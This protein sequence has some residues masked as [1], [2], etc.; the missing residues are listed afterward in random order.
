M[1]A[2]KWT[3]AL[4]RRLA[5]PARAED[6]VGDLEEA[7]ARRAARHARLVADALTSLEALD[8]ALALLRGRARKGRA[9]PDPTVSTPP[10]DGPDGPGSPG[11]IRFPGFSWLELKLGLRMLRKYPGLTLVG[12]LGMAV[13]IAI[14]A[15]FF[16]FFSA[17]IYPT[18]PLEGGDR[19]VGV[20]NWDV[21]RNNEDRRSLHDFVNWR[22]ELTTVEDLTAFRTVSR[23]L[24][25]LD[26]TAELITVAEMTPSGFRLARVRPLLGRYLLAPDTVQGAEPVIVI[27]YDVWQARFGGDPEIIGRTLRLGATPYTVVGV[28]PEGFAFPMEHSF[29]VPLRVNASD[30]PRGFGPSIFISGRLAPGRTMEE[31]QA[32][33]V[34]IGRRATAAF[35]DTHA[36]LRPHVLPYTYPLIDI[37]DPGGGITWYFAVMQMIL[38][39]ILVVVCVN[40]AI[41]VYAR[42]AARQGEIAVRC[43]LGASRRQVVVQLFMEALV[44]SSAAAL[45]GLGI[46]QIGLRIGHR[47]MELEGGTPFWMNYGLTPAT[48]LYVVGLTLLS[49]LITGVLPALQATGRRMQASLR[50]LGGHT[51]LRLGR[52]WTALVVIQVA[53]AV[54]ALPAALAM[55]WQEV[56]SATTRPTYPI[57]EYVLAQVAPDPEPPPGLDQETY[58]E[59]LAVRQEELGPELVRQ[60]RELPGVSGVALSL[61]LPGR[62]SSAAVEVEGGLTGQP[63]AGGPRVEVSLVG[64][65]FFRVFE[66]PLLAGRE[67]GGTDAD[68]ASAAVV[69]NRT[70]AQQLFVGG[71]AVGRRIRL[72]PPESGPNPIPTAD[73][74]WLEIVGVVGDLEVNDFDPSLVSAVVYQPM[75]PRGLQLLNLTVRV[76]EA[77]SV[78]V[79][80]SIRRTVASLDPTLRVVVRP[81]AYL[82]EEWE[83][84]VHLAAFVFALVLVSVLLLSAAGIYALMSFTVTQRRREIGIRNALGARPR[85]LL[86]GIF[87]R[88]LRQLTLGVLLGAVAAVLLDRFA[89]GEILHGHTVTLL[90]LIVVLMIAVGLLAALGP[91]LR[92]LRI[93]P[94]EALKSE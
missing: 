56:R 21:A 66:L 57:D 19:L 25:T 27:G 5:P 17:Y 39:L 29:W 7:H 78:G 2:P 3:G 65:E 33:I 18:I 80:G 32:Q 77:A 68:T 67:F 69:V 85:R 87:A 40:V 74:P 14:G 9:L 35:P 26:G 30:Y 31:A 53:V 63:T 38:S 92:G 48:V 16:S 6:V 94:A 41:L 44:L 46:A 61:T 59:Q 34:A 36:N 4:L 10:P 49:A 72:V 13:A 75:V 15:G 79:P 12:G 24:V 28:M 93:Q 90:P 89:G 88:A 84:V 91:A 8:M 43:A 42:T 23:N 47:L 83:M 54:A 20:E 82:Y 60:I 22:E 58:L 64:R 1:N 51:G 45:A 76:N 37:N 70:F 55:G 62:G 73:L 71:E 50:D 52:T 81:L 86:G 11:R